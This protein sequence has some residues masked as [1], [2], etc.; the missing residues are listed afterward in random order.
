VNSA[1]VRKEARKSCEVDM[2][3]VRVAAGLAALALMGGAL[4]GC[5]SSSSG[6]SSNS[7]GTI[8]LG[9]WFPLTGAQ[10][11]SGIPLSK[12]VEAYF[13]QLNASGGINGHKV[14][15]IAE[16]DAF[17]PQQT[18]QIAR[19]LVSEKH[20]A[21]IVSSDGTATTAAT[22]PFVLRQSKVPIFGTYGGDASWYT[23]PQ[24]GLFGTLALYEDQ[25]AVATD[26]AIESGAKHLT[27]VRDDP[28]AFAHVSTTAMKHA[29]GKGITA[30]EVVT[31]IGTTDYAPVISQVRAKG[32]DAV[33]LILPPQEA[34]AYLK[35]AQL[36]GLKAQ[37]Y[38]YAPA[39]SGAML[40]LAGSAANGFRGVSL[41]VQTDGDSAQLKQ[42][43]DAMSTYAK[44]APDPYS[45]TSYA[46]ADAFTQILKTITGPIDS[47]SIAKAIQ[48]A[49]G[50]DTGLTPVMSFSADSHLGIHAVMRVE[51][52]N[53]KLVPRG[54][55]VTPQN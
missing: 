6:S 35:E 34:A 19:Q 44:A 11:S 46:T 24:A 36:Q 40:T 29:Q 1:Q 14:E 26:W 49:S 8:K 37:A 39:S 23:P 5:A 15:F 53:G 9:A 27:V 41:S 22:F 16:D 21:A 33:L 50:I 43:R 12:G 54:G 4:T 28:A 3:A 13:D 32:S 25:A 20:V 38:G 2:K 52:V 42:Y 30:D 48:S 17:D 51:A 18:L 10:A 45:L 47:A 7:D 31:K 55:F